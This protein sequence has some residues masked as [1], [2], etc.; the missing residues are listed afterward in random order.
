MSAIEAVI[1]AICQFTML[2]LLL[3]IDAKLAARRQD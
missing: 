1:G 3:W 2:G